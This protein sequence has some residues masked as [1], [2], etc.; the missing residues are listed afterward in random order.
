[1]KEEAAAAGGKIEAIYYCPHDWNAGCE[2]RKPLPGMLFQA[3]H[4]LNFDLSRTFFAGDDERDREAAERAGCLF[5]RDRL[6]LARSSPGSKS[7]STRQPQRRGKSMK[8][9][10]LLTGHNGYIGSVMGPILAEAGHEVVGVDTGYFDPCTLVPDKVRVPAIQK[11]IR[12]LSAADL[13]GFHAV[14]HLAALS[15]DPIGNLDAEWTRQIND[16]GTSAPG[17]HG[18]GGRSGAFSVLLV[19][20]HVRHVRSQRGRRRFAAGPAHRIRAFQGA[21]R[22]SGRASSP[23]TASRLPFCA[24]ARS[25]ACR[26]ACA[27]TPC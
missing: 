25:T 14:I 16:E 22:R 15:N 17:R 18:Q 20:H 4:D 21:R 10:V 7:S 11:D 12:D 8:T 23:A 27:S 3:Q 9:R 26:R 1:M 19:V 2:C 13:D 6:E 24:T 5:A